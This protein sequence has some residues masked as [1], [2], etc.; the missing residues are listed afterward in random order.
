MAYTKK[1][2]AKPKAAAPVGGGGGHAAVVGFSQ[3]KKKPPKKKKPAKTN[4]QSIKQVGDGEA[5]LVSISRLVGSR[6]KRVGVRV[7]SNGNEAYKAA[8]RT[9]M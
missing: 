7:G 4:K 2:P 8:N 3:K 5:V 1:S 9:S 6:W